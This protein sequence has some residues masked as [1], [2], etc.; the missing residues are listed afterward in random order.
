MNYWY[1][2]GVGLR[3]SETR[4]DGVAVEIPPDTY[5][6]CLENYSMLDIGYDDGIFFARI[7][8]RA[9]RAAAL[10]KLENLNYITHKGVQY[11]D[12]ELLY[13]SES[14]YTRSGYR[15]VL[16]QAEMITLVTNRNRRYALQRRNIA[17]AECAEE[18]DAYLR[19]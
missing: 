4:P 9:Y 15:C 19:D 13:L 10:S 14:Y 1:V 2:K 3:K 12:D 7:D 17:D 16:T 6:H 5:H 11:F 18:I 8:L